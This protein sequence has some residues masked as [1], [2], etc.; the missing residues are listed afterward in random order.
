MTRS[1]ESTCPPSTAVDVPGTAVLP[2]LLPEVAV[3]RTV[4]ASLREHLGRHGTRPSCAGDWRHRQRLIDEVARANLTGRG[5]AAFPTA[6]KLRALA[7]AARPPVVIAN[8]VEGEP[9][10]A[11]DKVLLRS[12]PHLVLDGA[13]CAAELT[14]AS[15]VVIVAHRAVWEAVHQ[16]AEERRRAGCDPVPVRVRAA[17]AGFTAGEASAVVHWAERGVPAPTGRPPRLGGPGR[18]PATL[19][20]N[21]E[22]LAHLAL[23]MRYGASWFSSAG[24]PAEPGTRL[25]T[26]L[27]AVRNPGVYEVETGMLVGD[28]LKLA[29]NDGAPLGALLIGGYFGTWAVAAD[30]LSLPFSAAGLAAAGA[31]PGAGVVAALP[32]T[33][34][35]LAET[36]RLTRYL[37]GSSAGQCGPCVFGLDAIARELEQA[38]AGASCDLI[39]V[40]RWLGDVTGRGAC[41]HPDGTALMV[42]SAL[43]VFRAEIGLHTRGCC[44]ATQTTGVL[45]VHDQVLP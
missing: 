41:R 19:V 16:A 42:A 11:K 32:A 21:V 33:A 27:G 36:A 1:P 18:R 13:V 37:A 9:A 34:C 23:I 7:G 29:G 14:G 39:R 2:R 20:Q 10:S 8:G 40:R 30:A 28:M 25:V 31:S 38:A 22:T 17:A 43:R 15:E 45:P 35:G 12:A 5:G 3:G 26:L 44:S 4:S 6:V 24:T